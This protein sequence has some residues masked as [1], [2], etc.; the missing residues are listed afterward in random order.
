MEVELGPREATFY[1]DSERGVL[2]EC[3]STSQVQQRFDGTTSVTAIKVKLRLLDPPIT[4]PQITLPRKVSDGSI[5]RFSFRNGMP[6]NATS[7]W[8]D[9]LG[10][11]VLAHVTPFANRMSLNYLEWHIAVRVKDAGIRTVDVYDVTRDKSR[12]VNDRPFKVPDERVMHLLFEKL[13][14]TDPSVA[15]FFE[16][17]VTER[18]FQIVGRDSS[19]KTKTIYQAVII[20]TEKL[21]NDIQSYRRP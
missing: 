9:V 6:E 2:V 12:Q 19:G 15:W 11:G 1:F 10:T 16:D 14:P 20:A 8:L 17:V 5:Q 3:D 13:P 4:I 7:D 18:L 21:R